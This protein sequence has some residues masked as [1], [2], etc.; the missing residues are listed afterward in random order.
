MSYGIQFSGAF[1]II[2]GLCIVPVLLYDCIKEL[3]VKHKR[4]KPQY[5]IVHKSSFYIN[6]MKGYQLVPEYSQPETEDMKL[7]LN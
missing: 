4:E 5:Q 3:W 1:Y 2:A 7:P 6:K